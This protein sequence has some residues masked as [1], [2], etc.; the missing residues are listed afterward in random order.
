[1]SCYDCRVFIDQVLVALEAAFIL[2]FDSNAIPMSLDS[3]ILALLT[4]YYLR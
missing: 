2:N 1:M 3:L 4:I